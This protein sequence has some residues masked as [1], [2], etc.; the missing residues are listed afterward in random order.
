MEVKRIE[1]AL[2]AAG[3]ERT[4]SL[5][6]SAQEMARRAVEITMAGEAVA[7]AGGD[8]TIGLVVDA[9]VRAEVADPLVG[10]IPCGTGCDLPRTFGISPIIEDAVFHLAGDGEYRLDVGRLEGEFGVRHFVNVAQTG[11]GAA[12]AETALRLPRRLGSVRYPMAFAARLPGFPRSRVTVDGVGSLT[13]DAL[14]VIFANGQFFA[15]GWNIAPK[16]LMGDGELDVQ[17]ITARK[18]EA[19]GL[20]PKLV[21]GVHLTHASVT[22]RSLAEFSLSTRDRWPIEADGDFIGYTPVRVTTL[23]GRIRLKI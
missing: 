1:A 7:V 19:P 8:G 13:G 18:A 21:Q 10:M 6:D 3:V 4:V 17:M 20:V 11:V 16:A 12:A 5:I 22:R 9:L 14:A 2:E 15:G 23:P